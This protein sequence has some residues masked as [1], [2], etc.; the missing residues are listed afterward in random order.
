MTRVAPLPV[1]HA[2]VVLPAELCETDRDL[3]AFKRVALEV[4]DREQLR[5]GIST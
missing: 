1:G 5:L 2:V 4:G 3:N